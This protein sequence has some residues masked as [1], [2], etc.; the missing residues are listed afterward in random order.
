VQ[1]WFVGLIIGFGLLL[2]FM[3][4]DVNYFLFPIYEEWHPWIAAIG[5]FF[6]VAGLYRYIKDYLS[7]DRIFGIQVNR[8]FNPLILL[9]F[10]ICLNFALNLYSIGGNVAI[11]E[12]YFRLFIGSIVVNFLTA[13]M[14]GVMMMFRGNLYA[15]F[16]VIA[17]GALLV[18]L[19]IR[20]GFA[21][22]SFAGDSGF[23][24]SAISTGVY[25]HYLLF[26]GVTMMIVLLA[27]GN[28]YRINQLKK[29]AVDAALKSQEKDLVNDFLRENNEAIKVKSDE[30][31]LLVKEIH[32]RVKNNLQVLASLLNLQS[33]YVTDEAAYSALME[34]KARVEAMGMIHQL[35][36]LGDSGRPSIDMSL[37]LDELC[38]YYEESFISDNQNIEKGRWRISSQRNYQKTYVS[39]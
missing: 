30:N 23:N 12:A 2:G 3:G 32:H 38:S 10:F 16:F 21:F 8:I 35:L 18:I 27:F 7:L 36:Y 15:R 22:G 33:D 6:I 37:Y 31:K 17:F 5:G 13:L 34:S 28:G 11:F 26:L 25:V 1:F 4:A 14:I 19:L 29:S 9:H 20:L 39:S 24:Q